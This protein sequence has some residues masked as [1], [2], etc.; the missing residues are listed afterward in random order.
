MATKKKTAPAKAVASDNTSTSLETAWDRPFADEGD[1]MAIGLD[2]NTAGEVNW[3]Q[4]YTRRYSFSISEGG[5]YIERK[6]FNQIIY[7]I[8]S[9][10]LWFKR[11]I[12]QAGQALTQNLTW[13]VGATGDFQTLTAA[14][15]KACEYHPSVTITGS[16]FKISILIQ[17]NYTLNEPITLKNTDL[18]FVEIGMD[19]GVDSVKLSISTTAQIGQGT[20]FFNLDNAFL[21]FGKIK[22]SLIRG[23]DE[24]NFVS[25]IFKLKNNSILKA[26]SITIVS[27][28]SADPAIQ[29]DNVFAEN[30]KILINKLT[31][32]AISHLTFYFNVCDVH[33]SDALIIQIK[34]LLL[35]EIL[36]AQN[37]TLTIL[38]INTSGV[39]KMFKLVNSKLRLDYIIASGIL[40]LFAA[41]SSNIQ[42]LNSN[43]SAPQITQITD[44]KTINDIVTGDLS[45]LFVLKNSVLNCNIF[46]SNQ[47][48]YFLYAYNSEVNFNILSISYSEISNSDKFKETAGVVECINSKFDIGQLFLSTNNTMILK[49]DKDFAYGALNFK[50]S[51]INIKIIMLSTFNI[52]LLKTIVTYD[53]TTENIDINRYGITTLYGCIANVSTFNYNEDTLTIDTRKRTFNSPVQSDYTDENLNKPPY[54]TINAFVLDLNTFSSLNLSTSNALDLSQT[55]PEETKKHLYHSNLTPFTYNKGGVFAYTPPPVPVNPLPAPVDPLPPLPPIFIKNLGNGYYLTAD[56]KKVRMPK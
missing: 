9:K 28:P 45:P 39:L 11:A 21:N 44:F 2:A 29:I 14:L 16:D 47:I 49:Y 53:R 25:K 41:E 43:K 6:T 19:D 3:K 20:G 26:N 33:I 12:E 15:E 32:Q 31:T 48:N 37:T 56:G 38:G 5:K 10:I 23:A 13:K 34:D 35:D 4:G 27:D 51:Q 46:Q 22:F 18:S 55:A 50:N 7:M 17:A 24:H 1:R 40:Q 8:T 42:I 36:Y 54:C 52:S 30:S